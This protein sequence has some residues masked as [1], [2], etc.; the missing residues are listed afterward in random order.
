[1]MRNASHTRQRPRRI[2]TSRLNA[3]APAADVEIVQMTDVILILMPGHFERLDDETLATSF[4]ATNIDRPTTGVLACT[5][6][7]ALVHDIER[8]PAVAY[9]R[10]VQAYT[11]SFDA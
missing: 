4:A 8:N 10:R 11:G 6:P 3:L 9:L 1:M 2:A 7:S 5:V